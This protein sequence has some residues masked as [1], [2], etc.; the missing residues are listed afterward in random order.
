M[1]FVGPFLTGLHWSPHSSGQQRAFLGT[2]LSAVDSCTELVLICVSFWRVG[3]E[4]SHSR[5]R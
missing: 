2:S 3:S 5:R 1:F 4:M